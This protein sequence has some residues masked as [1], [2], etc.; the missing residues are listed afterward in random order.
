MLLV[1]IFVQTDTPTLPSIWARLIDT[2]GLIS[3]VSRNDTIQDL[4][5]FVWKLSGKK[6]NTIQ[7]A[8]DRNADFKGYIVVTN[9][10]INTD[11]QNRAAFIS[12]VRQIHNINTERRK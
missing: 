3:G 11:W 7:F 9:Q 1:Y 12:K 6:N 4:N 10:N 2:E 5:Q 8:V